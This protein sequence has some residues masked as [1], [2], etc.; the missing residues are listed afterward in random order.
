MTTA[1][2]LA[3]LLLVPAPQGVPDA[4][5]TR[6]SE[7][8]RLARVAGDAVWTGWS[9]A[10]FA[11]VLVTPEREFFIGHPHPPADARSLGKDPALGQEVFVRPRTFETSFLA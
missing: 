10:P 11:V 8:F 9:G 1:A 6:L 2:L 3:A 7:A 4:D 5:R